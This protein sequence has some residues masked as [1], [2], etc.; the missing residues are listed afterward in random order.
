MRILRPAELRSLPLEELKSLVL[1]SRPEPG[2][3]RT[4]WWLGLVEQLIAEFGR[5]RATTPNAQVENIRRAVSVIGLL[6]ESADMPSSGPATLMVDLRIAAM[7]FIREE[8]LPEELA[9][10]SLAS[11]CLGAMPV[12]KSR[13]PE[14]IRRE[15]HYLVDGL[16]QSDLSEADFE[17]FDQLDDV[18]TVLRALKRLRPDI[19]DKGLA[20]LADEWIALEPT[21]HGQ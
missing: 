5:G 1:S 21:L 12:N 11:R 9:A 19:S 3:V 20:A 15:R 4:S 17:E 14:L 2:G 16:G 18:R 13:L 7:A 8:Q 6:E 10:N